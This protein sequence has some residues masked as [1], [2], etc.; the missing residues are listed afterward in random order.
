MAFVP[1]PLTAEFEL[2]YN[3]DGQICENTFG[4][5]YA[6]DPSEVSL[7]NTAA[8]FHS[9]FTG[10]LGP[11]LCS[12][13][14]LSVIRARSLVEEHGIGIDETTGLPEPATGPSD[15]EAG[16]VAPCISFKTGLTGR[17]HRGRNYIVGV[18]KEVTVK[19]ILNSGWIA[20]VTTAYSAL[21]GMLDAEG[22]TWVVISRFSGVDPITHKPIPRVTGVTTPVTNVGFT[23]NVVDSQR[24]RLPSRGQ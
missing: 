2:V 17:S 13:L 8:V 6:A 14:V 3:Y 5:R 19:G 9:W 10:A 24:R 16:N 21:R 15:G 22:S 18:P 4:V 23:D 11:N 7:R 1:V 12:G 20:T